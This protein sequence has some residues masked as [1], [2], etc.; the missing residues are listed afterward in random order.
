MRGYL[1]HSLVVI[2][3]P[4]DK[5]PFADSRAMEASREIAREAK[6][7]INLLA[8]RVPG[9]CAFIKAPEQPSAPAQRVAVLSDFHIGDNL[10]TLTAGKAVEALCDALEGMGE[11]DELVLLGDIFDLW[12][13]PVGDA[14]ERGKGVLG[15]L[16]ALENV[17]KFV[18]IPGNHDHHICRM[19]YEEEMGRRLRKGDLEPPE[20]SI[21]PTEDCPVMVPL[22]P[23]GEG[24]PLVM[25]YPMYQ[26]TVQGKRVLF[27]HGHLLG[28]FERNLWM[29][30]A[31]M[32]TL[33]LNKGDSLN[34]E[35]VEKFASPYY[36]MLALS[37][38]M[39]GVVDGRYRVYRAMVRA[40]KA[41][42]LAGEARESSLRDTT[43]EQNAVEIEAFLDQFCEEKPDFFI[44][45][46]TH[47]AG[48]LTLPLSGVTA[49][50]SG[51]WIANGTASAVNTLVEITDDARLMKL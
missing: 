30:N 19:Y 12:Q 1:E 34:M 2:D 22:R 27:T 5:R 50:N 31:V 23:E 36:E 15:D 44:Y 17:K 26:L 14:I 18:Y 48:K 51:C 20:L 25:T 40:G 33:L 16:F 42:G 47:K 46:H 11:L 39:P 41:L 24:P 43:V 9:V 35:D 49:V 3:M 45:G 8:S 10:S 21:L 28:F 7:R 4:E 32:S 37:T 29:R 6:R 38:S 13:V